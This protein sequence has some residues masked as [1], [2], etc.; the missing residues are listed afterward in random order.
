ML[1]GSSIFKVLHVFFLSDFTGLF[2]SFL[3]FCLVHSFTIPKHASSSYCNAQS[4]DNIHN[5]FFK[6][7]VLVYAVFTVRD[8]TVLIILFQDRSL[9]S[10][11]YEHLTWKSQ[12]KYQN[13]TSQ[14]DKGGIFIHLTRFAHVFLGNIL[15]E[16][17]ISLWS[18]ILWLLLYLGLWPTFSLCSLYIHAVKVYYFSTTTFWKIR[19]SSKEKKE[20]KRSSNL[21]HGTNWGFL[22]LLGNGAGWIAYCPNLVFSFISFFCELLQNLT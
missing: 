2:R 6:W 18:L 14:S 9:I 15:L 3:N 11:E 5:F 20:K 19:K 7:S 16:W 22:W 10:A 21:F 17:F 12:N 8:I 13:V 4:A 1:W